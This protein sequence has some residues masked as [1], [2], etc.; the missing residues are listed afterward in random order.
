M[1][2]DF[3]KRSRRFDLIIIVL[4]SAFRNEQ[5]QIVKEMVTEFIKANPGQVILYVVHAIV[6]WRIGNIDSARTGFS[7]ALSTS[8]SMSDIQPTDTVLIRR[9]W[10]LE[11]LYGQNK[12]QALQILLAIPDSCEIAKREY[13]IPTVLRARKVTQFEDDS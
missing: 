1:L 10:A 2:M 13:S 5:K 6:E 11:E 3:S 12:S 9:S 8:Q 4:A 7:T